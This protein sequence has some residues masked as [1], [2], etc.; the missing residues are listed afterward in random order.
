MLFFFDF[1]IKINLIRIPSDAYW[2]YEKHIQVSYHLRKIYLLSMNH[3]LFRSCE[4]PHPPTR[5]RNLFPPSVYGF[6]TWWDVKYSGMA[7][8]DLKSNGLKIYQSRVCSLWHYLPFVKCIPSKLLLYLSRHHREAILV[9]FPTNNCSV[10]Q[11]Q[12][13]QDLV[14]H[15]RPL[16]GSLQKPGSHRRKLR[17]AR[18]CLSNRSFRVH[19]ITKR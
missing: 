11:P 6:W 12:N 2:T 18:G 13:S 19:P 9:S 3:T 4:S 15:R 8:N 10:F 7:K 5:K 16:W 17:T 14:S 1:Q